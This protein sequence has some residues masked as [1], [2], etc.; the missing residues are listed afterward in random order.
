MLLI[1][2]ENSKL[3][4]LT[5]EDNTLSVLMH[6]KTF[7]CVKK[8]QNVAADMICFAHAFWGVGLTSMHLT[9]KKQ[10]CRVCNNKKYADT[11]R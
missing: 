9:A 4:Y 7:L 5:A 3:F 10:I 6:R 1:V 2:N 8:D 11:K